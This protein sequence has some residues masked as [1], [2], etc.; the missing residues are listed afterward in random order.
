[1]LF[2]PPPALYPGLEWWWQWISNSCNITSSNEWTSRKVSSLHLDPGAECS[3]SDLSNANNRLRMDTADWCNR[4]RCIR[5]HATALPKSDEPSSYARSGGGTFLL[6]CAKEDWYLYGS[7]MNLTEI[8][9]SFVS[10]PHIFWETMEV[11]QSV[12]LGA[13]IPLTLWSH[14]L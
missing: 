11:C 8:P 1:M 14:L 7:A 2:P 6:S 5:L 10:G 13:Q 3:A 4:K 12:L 9:L